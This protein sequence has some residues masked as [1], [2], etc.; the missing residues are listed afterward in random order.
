MRGEVRPLRDVRVG[1]CEDAV[2][3]IQWQLG[4]DSA[5]Y[6]F[7]REITEQEAKP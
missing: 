3:F 6:L 5:R 1:L 7:R 4:R 2:K